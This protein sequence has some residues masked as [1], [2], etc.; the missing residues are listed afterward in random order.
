INEST[1]ARPTSAARQRRI[2]FRLGRPVAEFSRQAIQ[3]NNVGHSYSSK[4]RQHEPVE[5]DRF[6]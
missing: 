6:L 2:A 3:R 5:V 4:R 1:G